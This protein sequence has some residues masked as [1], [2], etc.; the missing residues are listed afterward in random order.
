MHLLRISRER[1][2]SSAQMGPAVMF[3]QVFKAF[4][5][6]QVLRDVSF[7]VPAGQVMCI[8]GR[9]G[10]GKSVTLKLLMALLKPDRGSIW[11]DGNDVTRLKPSGLSKG[12][13]RWAFS[14]RT[15]RSSTH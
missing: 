15:R 4:G 11:V 7:S 8:L 3:D 13:A 2:M 9:S 12:A 5:S 14:S 10:T 1:A 6:H